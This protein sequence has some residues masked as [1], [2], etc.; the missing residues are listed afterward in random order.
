MI[1]GKRYTPELVLSIA[2]RRKWLIAIPTVLVAVVA[3][4]VTYLLPDLYRSEASI[5]VIPPRVSENYIRSNVTTGIEA[6]LRSINQQVRS[7]TKLERI[8][9][10]LNLYPDRR[11]TD[12][13]QDIVDD[14]SRAIDVT[15]VQGD[16]FRIAFTSDTP[17]TAMQV[18][19]RL[20]TFFIDESLKNRT[21]LAEQADNFLETVAADAS[22]K[23]R[24][25]E[26][27]IA[28][29]KRKHDGELPTQ[30]NVNQQGLNNAQMQRQ[31][32]ELSL[33]RARD[34][35]QSV[36]RRIQELALQAEAAA[37]APIS[38]Q[39]A[40]LS[41]AGQLETAKAELQTLQGRYAPTH[42]RVERARQRVAQLESEAAE[43][44]AG[45]TALGPQV[46]AN[47]ML[48]SRLKQLEDARLELESVNRQ[49]ARYEV[50]QRNLSRSISEYQ[51]RMELTPLRDTEL[52]ELTRDY[53][54]LRAS[55]DSLTA[56]KIDSQMSVTLERRQI[57]EQFNILDPARLPEKPSSPNRGRLY[58]L[59][60]LLAIGVG[61]GLAVGAE[62]LDRG[63]RS[64]DDVRLALALPVLATIP[65][66][67]GTKKKL[68][69]W[70]KV[71]AGS[72]AAAV[73]AVA[74]GVVWFSLR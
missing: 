12:I 20:T 50:D 3:C 6:R 24:E 13:M 74:V 46:V 72:A 34:L 31:S 35:Q 57:G 68:T 15:I 49:I 63:L 60:I 58:L 29:Y 9:E 4:V 10:D 2:W 51:R 27:K 44:S 33:D 14:M 48:A 19:E 67:G 41:K 59:S 21:Q 22:R 32:T 52:V 16:I 1:P 30:E 54:T 8:I 36:Q 17:R 5:L 66:I 69:L 45:N 62:Y 53:A 71:A 43:E 47:P 18:T 61:L 70:K 7:R 28:E 64:E 23:L 42:P 65:V 37:A 39:E 40:P 56:K 55:Y 38:A 25:T 11:K 26:Q 73:L